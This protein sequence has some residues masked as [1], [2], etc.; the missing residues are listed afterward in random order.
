MVK[1]NI[2][3]RAIPI[4]SYFLFSILIFVMPLIETVGNSPNNILDVIFLNFN[5]FSNLNLDKFDVKLLIMFSVLFFII[6]NSHI[7]SIDEETSF[8]SMIL[9]RTG[10]IGYIKYSLSENLKNFLE[11]SCLIAVSLA[12]SILMMGIIFHF[13][14]LDVM[15]N[16]GLRSIIY[17]IRYNLVVA[18]VIYLVKFGNMV[19]KSQ[20]ILIIPYVIYISV[21]MIDFSF[22]TSIITISSS[23]VSELVY[24]LVICVSSIII[25]VFLH[26][27][28]QKFKEVYI[29]D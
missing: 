15:L 28:F 8:S 4:L 6:Y 20:Y 12:V 24:L 5:M 16:G 14:G 27:Y 7:S 10:K 9:Y 22:T 21:L 2:V 13:Q 1:L 11:D 25:R 17:I 3:K 18:T 26:V 23:I 29:N 19:I